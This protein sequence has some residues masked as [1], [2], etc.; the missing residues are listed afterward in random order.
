MWVGVGLYFLAEMTNFRKFCAAVIFGSLYLD[1][2]H[3]DINKLIA[4][5]SSLSLSWYKENEAKERS[6]LGNSLTKN[7]I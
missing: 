6:R 2:E 4:S 3:K 1:K 5:K 7:L